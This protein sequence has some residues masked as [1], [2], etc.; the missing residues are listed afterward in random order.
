MYVEILNFISEHSEV[1]WEASTP[2]ETLIET[3]SILSILISRFPSFV[4]TA[5]V[6]SLAIDVMAPLLNHPRPAVRKRT[7]VTLSQ[8]L[9]TMPQAL[10]MEVY[11]TTITPGLSGA[12]GLEGEKTIV[13]LISTIARHSPQK[14]S[15][16][17]GNIVPIVLQDTSKD[18]ED[19][20]DNALQVFWNQ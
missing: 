12:L 20:K 18:D 6:Q 1:F 7:I 8:F 9:Q 2:P 16:V 17:L 11:K 3:L 14:L 5:A 19:L 10:F 13:Q 4:S 15:V